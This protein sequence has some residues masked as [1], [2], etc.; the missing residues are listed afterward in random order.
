MNGILGRMGHVYR[1]LR[2][3]FKVRVAP[4]FLALL[5]TVVRTVVGTAMA[6][7]NLV[8]GRLR[9]T[10]ATRPIVLVGNPRTGTT[11]LQRFLS[12]EGFGKGMELFLMLYPS[13][14][15]QR[16]LRPLLP[17]LEK[18]SPAKFHTTDA[19]QTSLSSVETDDVAV[20]FRYLD[21]FFLYGFFLSFEDQ[22]MLPAFDPRVRDTS[23]RDFDWLDKLWRRSLVLHGTDRNIAKLFS[24]AVRLPQFLRR[25]PDAQ[26][27]YMARDPLSVIPSSMSLVIGVLDRA[28]GFWSLPEPVRKRWLDRM[29]KAWILLLQKFHEDWTTGA[30]DR[31]RVFIVRYDRMMADFEGMMDEM[32]AFL[33]HPMT[34]ELRA[35]IAKR[36]EK[37]RKYESEHK[38]DLEKFGLTE[39]Q[40][41]R[42][43]AFFYDTFLPPLGERPAA[44]VSAPSTRS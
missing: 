35:T 30:I 2:R 25:F 36:G 29:Y 26:I 16:L 38:Y 39:E 15:L 5:F 40:V 28:F 34:P 12:D 42:D 44:R 18:I 33:N 9:R 41:R 8:S 22:D 4:L 31:S 13:L 17:L 43:C 10:K 7:D 1:V 37:Q 32:C 14:L 20:L 19:H 6:L 23:A 27:L 21:G 11:F 24:V 3:T